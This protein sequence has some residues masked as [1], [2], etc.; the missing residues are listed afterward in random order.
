[1]LA[2]NGLV[3]GLGLLDLFIDGLLVLLPLADEG[4]EA[5]YQPGQHVVALPEDHVEVVPMN[6]DQAASV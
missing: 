5:F 1:M 6:A 2:K 3:V 4:L